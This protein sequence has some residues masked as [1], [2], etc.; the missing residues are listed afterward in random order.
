MLRITLLNNTNK[1]AVEDTTNDEWYEEWVC[2]FE[3]I[4]L[5]EIIN[6]IQE[7]HEDCD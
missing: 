6:S 4:T 1:F 2:P 3:N 7:E 5:K